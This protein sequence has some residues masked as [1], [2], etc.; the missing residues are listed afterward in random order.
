MSLHP[1]GIQEISPG[2]RSASG[3]TRSQDITRPRPG[4][5]PGRGRVMSLI[6]RSHGCASRPMATFL[7]RFAVRTACELNV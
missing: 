6:A 3:E 5:W 2:S 4:L 7:N 1:E